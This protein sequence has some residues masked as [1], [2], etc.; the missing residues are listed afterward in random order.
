MNIYR[1]LGSSLTILLA[2]CQKAAETGRF[3]PR[4]RW[5]KKNGQRIRVLR[6]Q[7]TLE[8]GSNEYFKKFSGNRFFYFFILKTLQ[9]LTKSLQKTYQSEL[10]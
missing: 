9:K 4:N 8:P 6:P 2:K 7:F 10:T 3:G 1:D 5:D